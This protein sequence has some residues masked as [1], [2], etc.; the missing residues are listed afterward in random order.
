M[1]QLEA[2]PKSYSQ[3]FNFFLN[4][5]KNILQPLFLVSKFSRLLL[6]VR[7]NIKE[8]KVFSKIRINLHAYPSVFFNPQFLSNCNKSGEFGYEKKSSTLS[9]VYLNVFDCS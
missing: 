4:C 1:L 2:N 7:G 3:D 8:K 6:R 5:Q 9:Q